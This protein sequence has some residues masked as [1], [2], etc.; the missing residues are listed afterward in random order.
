MVVAFIA[1]PVMGA[2]SAILPPRTYF[3]G[4]P[5]RLAGLLRM[6]GNR[7]ARSPPVIIAE[8]EVDELVLRLGKALDD[9]LAE[10][11]TG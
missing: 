4:D 6:I 2:G 10:I 5:G 7:I 1:E 3:R 8:S 11:E 9:T